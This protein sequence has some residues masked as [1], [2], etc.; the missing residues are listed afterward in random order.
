LSTGS[1]QVSVWKFFVSTLRSLAYSAA[2]PQIRIVAR[3][4][5]KWFPAHARDLPWRRTGDPYAIWVSEIML[6][7][8]QVKT[9]LPYW[10]RWMRALPTVSAVA[11]AR[12]NTI[13]KLWEG[14]GYYARARHLHQTAKLVVAKYGGRF[15]KEFDRLLGLP[16]I[17]RYTAGA[18]C[19]IAF[20][21]P[22]P[23]LDG[24]IVRVLA[25]L[26]GIDENPRTQRTQ[27]QLWQLAGEL[28]RAAAN[29]PSTG[30]RHCSALNQALM[31][32]G[33][34]VCTTRRPKCPLC[35]LRRH[36]VA[37]REQRIDELPVREPRAPSS[38]RRF[39]AFVIRAK[40]RVLLHQRPKGVVN[41]QLWEF[42]NLEILSGRCHAF[43]LAPAVLGFVPGSLRRLSVIRHRITRFR[44]S[45]HIFHAEHNGV[46][47][48]PWRKGHWCTLAELSRLPLPSAHRRIANLISHAQPKAT[49]T[50]CTAATKAATR[51][52]SG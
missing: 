15:P 51:V 7:Q 36:C 49:K 21:Q 23:I 18:I 28:V 44:I 45:L 11:E 6:Q 40:N 47:A 46:P 48:C 37:R 12:P 32:L 26:Y 4:L 35:P 1:F 19:S 3:A 2:V 29:A 5:L 8:T 42:P 27:Q 24:N 13:L 20:N 17:G 30:A 41:E 38:V 52:G 10:Q 50:V 39:A 14:L 33:A 9:V 22:T 34:L 25:R 31:E 43:Q 16:G